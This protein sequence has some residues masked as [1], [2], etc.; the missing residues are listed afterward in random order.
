MIIFETIIDMRRQVEQWRENGESI[1]LVPT[2]GFLH[3]GHLSLI[4]QSKKDNARTVV[5]IFINP[6]QFG[7]NEDLSAYPR[8]FENDKKLLNSAGVDAIFHPSA[9]EMYGVGSKTS[10]K[11]SG[12][13]EKLCGVTRPIHFE[14][15]A[16]VVTKLFNIVTPGK[17]Y[18]GSKD[19]QQLQVIKRM[20]KDLNYNIDIVGM[21][22][23]RDSDGLALSSR[24]IY[25]SKDE[26]EKALSLSR[27]LKYAGELAQSGEKDAK[28][29]IDIVSGMIAKEALKIDYVKLVDT[30]TL[31]DTET[32]KPQSAILLAVYVGR[33]R[34]ID[35]IIL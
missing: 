1:G 30:E 28:R 33:A 24:N 26:R 2:M 3:S 11:V 5:S 16:T 21:P 6:T 12:L 4:T 7:A 8:D 31:E 15:V 27:S 35:N 32:V 17:A 34:L 22:I 14:G 23:L 20:V 9:D 29:L 18:F 25:L 10:V 13:S 19:F